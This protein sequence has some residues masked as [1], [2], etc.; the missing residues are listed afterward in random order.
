MPYMNL[1]PSQVL[2][3][4]E[5]PRLPDGTSSDREAINRLLDDGA[6]SLLNLARDMARTG[7]AN[8]AELPISIKSGSKYLILEGNRRFAALK[9]L[10]D[11]A[12]AND[13]GHQKAFR[14][15]AALGTPPKTVYTLVAASRDEAEHWIMLRH[16]GEN[17]GVG[18][19]R[20]SAGQTAT[21][22]RR[23][24]KSVDSGTLRSIAIA[25]EIEEAYASDNEIIDLVRQVRRE[26][27][28]NIGRFFSPDILTTM[29]FSIR[30][31]ADS[32]IHERE[33]LVRHTTSQLRSFFFWALTYILKNPVDA[34]KN[35]AIRKMALK[36]AAHLLPS[37][38]DATDEPFRL[39]D[40]TNTTTSNSTQTSTPGTNGQTGAS[41]AGASGSS[42][43][44][45]SSGS[46]TNPSTQP[47]SNG[48]ATTST[49]GSTA[50]DKTQKRPPESK[51]ERF[52]LQGLKLPRHQARI[53]YL[54][55]ECRSL[56]LEEFPGVA[57]VMMRVIVELSVSSPEVLALSGAVE[58]DPLSKKITAMLKYLDPEIEHSMKRDKELAQAFMETSELGIQYLHGFVHNPAVSPDQH[59]ARRFSSA[60]RPFLE[61]VDEAL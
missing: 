23:I 1:R 18:T 15:A 55:K 61:R 51:P 32:S 3:D 36:S 54:L 22:R 11:P 34:Y 29:H 27:L 58:R 24:N 35:A 38:A 59:L 7:Q 25:D 44:G 33:L 48:G 8:P 26:K 40:G 37:L 46:A 60:Y 9:L 52:L 14:R 47:S 2:L 28:T 41:T 39:S 10:G 43:G 20:W 16:T 12:L 45:A 42:G 31:S 19:K 50:G 17:D 4:P 53:Q 5:N 57:C 21:H 56:D 30:T 49:T 6:D 13:E